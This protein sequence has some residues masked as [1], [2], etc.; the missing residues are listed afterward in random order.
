MDERKWTGVRSAGDQVAGAPAL[1]QYSKNADTSKE[2][3][4]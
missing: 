3:F 4:N 2:T 1:S